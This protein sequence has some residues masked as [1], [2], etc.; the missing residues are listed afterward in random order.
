MLPNL[1]KRRKWH[2]IQ[3]WIEKKAKH[4]LG[5]TLIIP[6]IK[7]RKNVNV[8][9]K[10]LHSWGARKQ[11]ES[12]SLTKEIVVFCWNIFSE[13]TAQLAIDNAVCEKF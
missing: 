3:K 1:K 10:D 12:N 13:N 6:N 2:T 11:F 8:I 7:G 5:T 9:G 4:L